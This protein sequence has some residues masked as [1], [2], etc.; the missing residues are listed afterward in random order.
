MCYQKNQQSI[1]QQMEDIRLRQ[2]E[3]KVQNHMINSW[4]N[5]IQNR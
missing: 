3:D 5:Q 1:L 4:L 2:D